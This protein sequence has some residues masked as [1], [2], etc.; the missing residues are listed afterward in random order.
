MGWD[1]KRTRQSVESY[2]REQFENLVDLHIAHPDAGEGAAYAACRIKSGH[3]LGVV[4]LFERSG[5]WISTKTMSED[6]GP[7]YY[8]CPPRIL[9]QLSPLEE[10]MP[11]GSSFE[12]AKEWRA[13]CKQRAKGAPR[14]VAVR[15][16][17]K[18]LGK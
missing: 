5:E 18:A 9:Q 10:F 16:L 1:G 6:M 14:R 4:I 17:A 11:A 7:Y 8:D 12:S 15:S 3:V 13:T 2:I